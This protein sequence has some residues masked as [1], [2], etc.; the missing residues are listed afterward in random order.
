[1]RVMSGSPVTEGRDVILESVADGVFTVDE[2]WGVTAF[3]RAAEQI[4]GVPRHGRNSKGT[5][6]RTAIPRR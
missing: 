3:N 1:M 5:D 4:T 2:E 6:E